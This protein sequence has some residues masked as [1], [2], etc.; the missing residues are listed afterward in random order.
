MS[1]LWTDNAF[2]FCSVLDE[3][4]QGT[5]NAVSPRVD[6][7]LAEVEAGDDVDDVEDWDAIAKQR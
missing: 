7:F 2:L 3:F 6:T 4:F 1:A 5:A